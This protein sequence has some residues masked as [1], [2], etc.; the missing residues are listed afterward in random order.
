MTAA[1]LLKL[2]NRPA[3]PVDDALDA[4]ADGGSLRTFCR[5]LGM[6]IAERRELWAMLRTTHAEAFQHAREC[7]A[8]WLSDECV[9]IADDCAGNVEGARLAIEARMARCAAL[10][11]AVY[12]DRKY[13]EHSGSVEL[14]LTTGA[15]A[16]Q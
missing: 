2:N 5:S 9:A 7:G 12:G 1:A 13:V 14:R 8:D 6:A 11:P 3:A 16:V 10:H 4:I 15:A